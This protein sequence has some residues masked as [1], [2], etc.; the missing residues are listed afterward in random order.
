MTRKTILLA[1][2]LAAPLAA[3]PQ[4]AAQGAPAAPDLSAPAPAVAPAAARALDVAPAPPAPAPDAGK[5]RH[6]FFPIWGDKARA[7]G[8]DLPEPFGFSVNY[9]NQTSDIEIAN[10]KLGFDGG[11]MYDASGLISVPAARTEASALNIRPNVMI[12]PFLTVYAVY[13]VGDTATN[14][15][16]RLGDGISFDTVA[17][18]GAQVVTVGGTL[19]GGYRGFFGVVDFNASVSD[20]DRLADTVGANL[21]SFRLGYNHRLNPRGRALAVWAGTAGQVLEVE[22]TGSVRMGD[23]IPPP[24]QAEIDAARARCAALPLAQRAACNAIVDRLEAYDGNTT[25]EYALDK[26]PAGV[27]NMALGAQYSLDRSWHFRFETT[28]LNGR[29]TY[30][31][32]TE[33]RFDVF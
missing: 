1:A 32:M 6:G 10:L 12:F 16:V 8:F 14:V 23:V 13:S 3:R 29:T 11:P 30:L 33:Y 5:Q 7:K 18:S 9:Y 21:L 31:A 22:T 25:V 17:E 20:V 15:N 2:L 19:Q 24:S 4:S 26:R 27:W 28:F